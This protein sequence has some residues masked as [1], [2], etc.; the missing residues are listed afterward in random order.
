MVHDRVDYG[1]NALVELPARNRRAS[2]LVS[3]RRFQFGVRV[4]NRRRSVSFP[5]AQRGAKIR[6]L[7]LEM[8]EQWLQFR[9]HRRAFN[10]RSIAIEPEQSRVCPMAGFPD[11]NIAYNVRVR[12]DILDKG[13][14]SRGSFPFHI[15]PQVIIPLVISSRVGPH[16]QS[17]ADR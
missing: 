7:S 16:L 4:D 11:V 13:G 17:Y 12:V 5:G 2:Q 6:G 15:P 10:A 1:R 14:T 9:A 8:S 3:Q